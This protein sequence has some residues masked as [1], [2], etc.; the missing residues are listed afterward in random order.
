V[1]TQ[2]QEDGVIRVSGVNAQWVLRI[3]DEVICIQATPPSGA[4]S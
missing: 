2:P 1:N 3:G 4:S